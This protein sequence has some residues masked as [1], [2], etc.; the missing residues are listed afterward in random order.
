MVDG[1]GGLWAAMVGPAFRV[2][3]SQVT[4]YTWKVEARLWDGLFAIHG[5]MDG[6]WVST[7]HLLHLYT[8]KQKSQK[9]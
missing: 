3:S 1:D 6:S 8:A 4:T 9:S 5:G 7:G 2:S